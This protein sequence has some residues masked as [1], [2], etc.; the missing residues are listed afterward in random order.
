MEQWVAAW[1]AATK[2]TFDCCCFAEPLVAVVQLVREDGV[3]GEHRGVEET[4]EQAHRR[5][6]AGVAEAAEGEEVHG[7]ERSR[8]AAID[9]LVKA[10]AEDGAAVAVGVIWR[11]LRAV[12]C[13]GRSLQRR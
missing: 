12:G 7:E 5:E 8:Q 6:R 3:G 1:A 4:A 11:P 2:S 9:H 13:S 10:A